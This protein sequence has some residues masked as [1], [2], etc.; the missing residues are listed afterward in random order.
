MV[1]AQA[2]APSLAVS[3]VTVLARAASPVSDHDGDASQSRSAI[4]VELLEGRDQERPGG[5]RFGALVHAILASIDLNAGAGEVERDAVLQQRMVD[6]T[7]VER[8]A[9]VTAVTR[10]LYHPVL[11]AAAT[12]T[13]VRRETP[14]FLT[15]EDGSLAEGVVDLAFREAR[16]GFEGWTVVDFK[17]D[18][19]FS[20][21]AERYRQQV[22][23]YVRAVQAATGLPARGLLLV[24]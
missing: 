18:G 5:R 24:I 21:E 4:T 2:S 12:A 13:Q 11:R 1:R 3:S 20:A 9:A 23:L 16:E 7:T 19:E 8:D 10:A 15:L 14:V 22:A 6:A 17:T